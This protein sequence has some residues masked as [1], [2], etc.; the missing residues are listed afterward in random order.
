MLIYKPKTRISPAV[1]LYKQ[2][3]VH[4]RRYRGSKINSS[5]RSQY[6]HLMEANW[7]K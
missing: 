2:L 3:Q 6:V 1:T 7:I 4:K 5:H